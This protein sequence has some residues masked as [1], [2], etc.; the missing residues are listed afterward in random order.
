MVTSYNWNE[1]KNLC[2]SQRGEADTAAVMLL[3]YLS[4]VDSFD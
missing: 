2:D 4:Y 3:D 1:R